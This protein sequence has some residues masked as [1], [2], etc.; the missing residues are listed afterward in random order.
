MT[1]ALPRGL[2]VTIDGPAGAGKS[3][4]AKALAAR[5]GYTY[6]DSGALYRAVALA[7]RD[8]GLDRD[9]E[10]GIAGLME[11]LEIKLETT[12]DG[13]RVVLNGKDV[14]FAIRK[15]EVG[16][17]ASAISKLA[18][19][20]Q[21]LTDLQRRLGAGGGVVLE[22]RDA[23]TVVFPQADIKFFLTADLEERTRRRF[24]QL[25]G[26]GIAADPERVRAEM[27]ARDDQDESRRIAPLQP[28][29]DAV[30]IDSSGLDF[31]AVLKLTIAEMDRIRGS[32]ERYE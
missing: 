28:P 24:A 29:Q 16:N 31:E 22:G 7:V 1:A 20:R 21:N 5:L 25:A 32:R 9:D 19:V 15:E 11:G 13:L 3:T 30:L 2:V 17:L 23:G 12:P 4:L 26:R 6:L 27:A 14:S 18:V 8:N 10:K